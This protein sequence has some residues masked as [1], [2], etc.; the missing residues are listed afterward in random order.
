MTFEEWW[1]YNYVRKGFMGDQ[2]GIL[3]EAFKQLAKKAWDE[4]QKTITL[5]EEVLVWA[6][7]TG[8]L[9]P[10]CPGHFMHLLIRAKNV[11]EELERTI[12]L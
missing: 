1:D 7:G 12:K 11:V 3:G 8:T 9:P 6:V 5:H 2:P 4:Q 10:T